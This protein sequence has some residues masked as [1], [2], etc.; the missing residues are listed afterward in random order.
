[1]VVVRAAGA[2]LKS[3]RERWGLDR[4]RHDN[5]QMDVEG[6]LRKARTG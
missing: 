1:M 3:L 2:R 6:C 4:M 5:V